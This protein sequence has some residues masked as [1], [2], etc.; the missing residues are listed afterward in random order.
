MNDQVFHAAM[1]QLIAE[2]AKENSRIGRAI[3]HLQVD[4]QEHQQSEAKRR[5]REDRFLKTLPSGH[6]ERPATYRETAKGRKTLKIGSPKI[7]TRQEER[8]RQRGSSTEEEPRMDSSRPST[9]GD[10]ANQAIPR[11]HAR[12]AEAMAAGR[13]ESEGADTHL[14]SR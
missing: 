12:C 8:S 5:A 13:R 14:S 1:Q 10:E 4:V 11:G 3:R 9:S 2:K 7:R 6:R